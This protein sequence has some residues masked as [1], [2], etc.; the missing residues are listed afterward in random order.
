[1]AVQRHSFGEKSVNAAG[2]QFAFFD[3]HPPVDDMT[4][5]VQRGL[6]ESPKKLSPKFFY[7]ERGSQ[8]FEAITRLEAYYPT[9]TELG[10]FDAHL[11]QIAALI[12]QDSCVVEYGS[13]SSLKIRKLLQA[14]APSAYV[15]IDISK[16]FL[17]SNAQ[18]LAKDFPSLHVFPVCAD[19]SQAI[20]LPP[21]TNGMHRVGF[22]PGSSIGNF[23]PEQARTF[24]TRVAGTLGRGGH[25]LIG[26]DCKKETKT[27]ELAYNDPDGVTAQFNL[28]AL[29]HLNRVLDA[30][31]NLRAF[32]HE[33]HYNEDLGCIQ[34]FLRSLVEQRVD[35]C[36]EHF[37]FAAGE[38]LHTEN[39]Y[40]YAPAEFVQL[41]GSAGF[42]CQQ[43]WL[44]EKAYFGLYLLR[45]R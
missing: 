25:L 41:A 39:S 19:F 4:A 21:Q 35:I 13:G 8:L 42:D 29:A 40:K 34:M 14:L 28:N 44:D 38:C 5:E 16:D 3:L 10:L 20:A 26:V 1:L 22:F 17:L 15:P 32:A 37:H 18:T 31:F 23:E 24:L 11:Q 30:D 33:A 27:L 12:G 2:Q 7:D 43:Q 6:Q 36:D 45:A 9:R